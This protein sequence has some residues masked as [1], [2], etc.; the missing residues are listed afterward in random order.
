M[1]AIADLEALAVT[2]FSL[3]RLAVEGLAPEVE[4][5]QF[6]DWLGNWP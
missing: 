5:K 3:D 1:F 6:Q 2:G 4:M